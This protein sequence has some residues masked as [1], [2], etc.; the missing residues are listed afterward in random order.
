MGGPLCAAARIHVIKAKSFIRL[1]VRFLS[2]HMN[3]RRFIIGISS[4]ASTFAILLGI[5]V[6][7]GWIFD[8]P[9]LMRVLPNAVAMKINTAI[10]FV[11]TG[12]CLRLQ[13]E[14]A[15]TK[16]RIRIARMCALLV[17]SVGVL[18]L[19][20]YLFDIDFGI[21]QILMHTPP[22]KVAPQ[23][24]GR[25]A[26]NTAL[27]F[28]L[29]GTSLLLLDNARRVLHMMAE[30]LAIVVL[31]GAFLAIVG[32]MLNVTALYGLTGYTTMA[33]H[34]AIGLEVLATGIIASRPQRGLAAVL[35]QDNPA[36]ATA[37][38]LLPLVIITPIIV[39]W[40]RLKGQQ[41][42]YYG[43]EFGLALTITVTA[44]IQA[45]LVLWNASVQGREERSRREATK[46]I[47]AVKD[48]AIFM[49][50][51]NGAVMTWNIGAERLKGY[52]AEEIIG[53]HFSCFYTEGDIKQ[54]KPDEYLRMADAHES[55]EDEGWLV[56][57][58]GSKFW[59]NTVITA[60]HNDQGQLLGFLKVTHDMT[61]H[62]QAS[63]QFRLAVEASPTA[64]VMVDRPGNIV[65]VNKQ[66]ET[67]FGYRREELIGKSIEILVPE[68]FRMSHS[69]Y[70]ASYFTNPEVR[71][72]GA[73]RDLYGLRKDGVEFP[74]EVALT[75]LQMPNR[76]FVLSSVID[77]TE[78]KR[79]ENERNDLAER[80]IKMVEL[81]AT[82]KE[83]EI[84]LQEI[85]HRV[86]NNLQIISSLI[87]LQ[88]SQGNELSS[89]EALADC[90]AQIQTI[91]LVHAMLY[92]SKDYLHIPFSEYVR[93]LATSVF[94]MMGATADRISLK[95]FLED[96]RLNVDMAV[97]F[98][99]ILNELISNALKHAFPQGRRGIIEVWLKA[100]D[101]D[102]L[103]LAV[104]DDGV[105]ISPEVDIW[106]SQSLGMKLVRSL[107][108]QIGAEIEIGQQGGTC[109]KLTVSTK[110]MT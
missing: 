101:C 66:V 13:I 90:K 104:K 41:A 34:T 26:P 50:D 33:F 43:T 108:Q 83:R 76:D 72:M 79:A 98:G 69:A 80:R 46:L 74:V 107:A 62:L 35:A 47:E 20:E 97:P 87:N 110:E 18:T 45:A 106:N 3:N 21:D 89:R 4:V 61:E 71:P 91:A 9:I 73:D 14:P 68:R 58:D 109:F 36:G 27:A 103:Y 7:F 15:V 57:K 60:L 31:V 94:N 48:Y 29:L 84:R 64:M 23:F 30:S 86:K 39:G 78:H 54:G 28:I 82:L 95:L 49:L 77:I 11:L 38:Y 44:G 37:R 42:G 81:S 1:F 56:R 10:A 5:S 40:L 70:R 32:Y 52:R 24:P 99:L 8:I 100:S 59:A 88:L 85:H 6:L 102:H 12:T 93:Q 75:P 105:G 63:E 53:K 19:N 25:M 65:M 16:Q 51:P 22:D 2:A 96:V 17:V 67:F 55:H 92:Q